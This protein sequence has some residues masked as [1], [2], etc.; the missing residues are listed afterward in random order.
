MHVA[1]ESVPTVSDADA[2]LKRQLRAD[3]SQIKCKVKRTAVMQKQKKAKKQAKKERRL[4]RDRVAKAL[5][6]AVR[7]PVSNRRRIIAPVKCACMGKALVSR[8]GRSHGALRIPNCVWFRQY[9]LSW[10]RRR[11]SKCPEPLRTRAKKTR[12]WSPLMTRRRGPFPIASGSLL[13]PFARCS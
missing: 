4:E 1:A 5:G 7:L 11:R 10:S 13:G 8:R 6:D 12:R 3:T 2:R 9:G